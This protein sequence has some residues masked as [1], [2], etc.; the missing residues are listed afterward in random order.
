MKCPARFQEFSR[1]ATPLLSVFVV[2]DNFLNIRAPQNIPKLCVI[3]GF[4]RTVNEEIRFS[5]T[6]RPLQMGSIGVPKLR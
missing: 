2:R 5:W 4:R 3:S 1:K 6:P